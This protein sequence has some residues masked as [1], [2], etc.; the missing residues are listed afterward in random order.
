MREYQYTPLDTSTGEIRLLELHPGAFDDPIN[1]SIFAVPFAAPQREFVPLDRIEAIRQSLP[2]GWLAFETIDDRVIFYDQT[3]R[4][5]TWKHPDPQAAHTAH[6]NHQKASDM[7]IP[8]FEALSYT[9]GAKRWRSPRINIAKA[10][11]KVR[12]NLLDALRHLRRSDAPRVLWIDAVSI[13]QNDLS[14]RSQQV[15]RMGDIFRCAHRVVVWL[16]AAS[17]TSS[18]ALSTL[19]RVADQIEYTKEALRLPS[20]DCVNKELH[21][22]YDASGIDPDPASW[23]AVDEF[24]RRPWF[25]R[26]WVVQEIRFATP[27]SLVQ[28]GND[29]I[30]WSKLRRVVIRGRNLRLPPDSPQKLTDRCQILFHLA[31]FHHYESPIELLRAIDALE[32]SDPRDKIYGV[33]GLFPPPLSEKIKPDYTKPVKEVYR[34][35]FTAYV[36]CTGSLDI[37]LT[38]GNSWVPDWSGSGWKFGPGGNFCCGKSSA[39]VAYPTPNVLQATGTFVDTVELCSKPRSDSNDSVKQVVWDLWLREVSVDS[40]YPT[41]ETVAEACAWTLSVGYLKDKFPR[42]PLHIT[43]AEAQ[44][45][46]LS[47]QR[48]GAP[49]QQV[50]RPFHS[51]VGTS[52]LFKTSKGYFGISPIEVRPGDELAVLLGCPFPVL[53]REQS[54][55]KHLFVGCV[56]MHGLMD[57]EALLGPLPQ[58]YGVQY[59]S[60]ENGDWHQIFVEP[61]TRQSSRSDPRLPPLPTPWERCVAPDRLWGAVKEVGAFK[62]K[63]TDEIMYTDPRMLPDALRARGV[64]LQEFL[65]L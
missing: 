13:N 55:G 19:K 11:L 21:N 56:Y 64:P 7:T 36:E 59:D 15:E 50:D 49:L 27:S 6:E 44:A 14:E 30:S 25:D 37:L 29:I 54:A 48:N 51:I 35:A 23:H 22:S 24:L 31:P 45:P 65:L 41:E 57:S 1:I 16:G 12:P 46:L 34:R 8:H 43:V 58:G 40:R 62:N 17:S 4:T 18:L 33:L 63:D 3:Q 20:P 47:M 52:F 26:I 60:D 2:P 10:S 53:L 39:N 9:W 38:A 28:C 32:C 61:S 5:T 42:V